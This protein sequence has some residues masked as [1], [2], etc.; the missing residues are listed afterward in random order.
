MKKHTDKHANIPSSI[1][2]NNPPKDI[3]PIEFTN[4]A[5]ANSRS[6]HKIEWLQFIVGIDR[7]V[8]RQSWSQF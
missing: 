3:E 1:G 7:P 2:H 8:R 5:H 4:S 6:K